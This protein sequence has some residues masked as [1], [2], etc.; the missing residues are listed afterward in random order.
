[1]LFSCD[2]LGESIL[3][4]IL[5]ALGVISFDDLTLRW[6]LIYIHILLVIL[7]GL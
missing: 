3:E 1:M 2:L 4:I 7:Q 6:S 5:I